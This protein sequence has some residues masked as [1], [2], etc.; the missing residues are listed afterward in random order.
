MVGDC[1]KHW[2][3]QATNFHERSAKYNLASQQFFHKSFLHNQS[4]LKL[5][6]RNVDKAIG[7]P[8][9]HDAA[10]CR[11]S[12]GTVAQS[13]T[14]M[15]NSK[16]R[17]ATDI[18]DDW[19]TSHVKELAGVQGVSSY[20]CPVPN[21]KQDG[22]QQQQRQLKRQRRLPHRVLNAQSKKHVNI[23]KSGSA[24]KTFIEYLGCGFD[25]VQEHITSEHRVKTTRSDFIDSKLD[26][27]SEDCTMPDKIGARKSSNPNSKY[28][29]TK[30]WHPF[31]THTMHM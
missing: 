8:L 17:T 16:V 20:A 6:C 7:M 31:G 27:L 26:G 10:R 19:D 5:I 15:K 4:T 28:V 23:L 12:N 18:I 13:E 24:D 22:L 25:E 30:D 2:L 14:V 29:F 21:S 11:V 9:K 1:S 3:S